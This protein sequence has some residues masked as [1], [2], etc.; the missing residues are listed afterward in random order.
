MAD[1]LADLVVV[2]VDLP[3]LGVASPPDVVLTA[4][5]HRV[6]GLTVD[7]W[8]GLGLIV[9]HGP[10]RSSDLGELACHIHAVQR[11]VLAQAA[12]RAYPD[13]YR[14]LGG[15]TPGVS[16]DGEELPPSAMV[17]AT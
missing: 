10:A 3:L 7:L 17:R 13:R 16:A 9:Q 15:D 5:E 11:A 2:D 14:L 8:H 1:D 6:M 4:A 12:A